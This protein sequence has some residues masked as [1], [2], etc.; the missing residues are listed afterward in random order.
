MDIETIQDALKC[1]EK[2]KIA[3]N[4]TVTI[5]V[6]QNSFDYDTIKINHINGDRINIV[7][8]CDGGICTI[9]FKPN[10]T[11]LI[12]ANGGTLG[13]FDN[14]KLVGQKVKPFLIHDYGILAENNGKIT[15][16]PNVTVRNFDY[17]VY[18]VDR[19]SVY[20][21]FLVSEHNNKDGVMAE[22][23]SIIEIANAKIEYNNG[24][25][26]KASNASTIKA[27]NAITAYNSNNGITAIN[28]AT[29][30]ARGIKADNNKGHN[31]YADNGS[32]IWLQGA[33]VDNNKK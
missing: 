22:R 23:G 26:I 18:A 7:G 16:G 30:D 9:V 32:I 1:L 21:P 31:F 33:I 19:S 12:V 11:G 2:A 10:T 8:D 28:I 13:L 3:P 6:T 4:V 17:G 14:F 15:C 25:G 20:A 27:P 24:N 5:K 29:V